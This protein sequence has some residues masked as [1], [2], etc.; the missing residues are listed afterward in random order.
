MTSDNAE[1]IWKVFCGELTQNPTDDMKEALA[2]A[3][4]ELAKVLFP[5]DV[6]YS[7]DRHNI[8]DEIIDLTIELDNLNM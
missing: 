3:F 2:T 8:Y 4:T 5:E 1:R 7:E 6:F